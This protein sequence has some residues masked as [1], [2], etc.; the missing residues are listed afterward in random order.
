MRRAEM[1]AD[2]PIFDPGHVPKA[3]AD[4]LVPSCGKY[5]PFREVHPDMLRTVATV[6]WSPFENVGVE[7]PETRGTRE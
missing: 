6:M 7:H 3:G 4:G 5:R 2:Q 1:G